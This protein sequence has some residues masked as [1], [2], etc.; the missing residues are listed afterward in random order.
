MELRLANINDLPQLKTMYKDIVEN[1]NKNEI[2]IWDDVYPSIFFES[3]ILNKQ[4]YLLMSDN[5]IVSAFCLSEDK[6]DSI[7]WKEPTARALY[8]QRFGVNVKYRQK[9]IG[10]LTLTKAKEITK[11][12]NYSY[13][14]LL[15]VDFNYPA[16]NLYL[17]NGFVKKDGLY[18]EIIDNETIL[19]EHGYEIEL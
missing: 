15:V 1:M 7:Q 14:R 9:G 18:R 11:K 12:L 3:D 6:V 19:Y 13:I 8:I 16:I 2:T 5:I 17:K 4:L 10:S